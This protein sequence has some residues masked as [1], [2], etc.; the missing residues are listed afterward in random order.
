[1]KTPEQN[2]LLRGWYK[3]ATARPLQHHLA[4]SLSQEKSDLCS[5]AGIDP[6][7]ANSWKLSVTLLTAG[8]AVLSCRVNAAVHHSMS[9]GTCECLLLCEAS[10]NHPLATS[11]SPCFHSNVNFSISYCIVASLCLQDSPF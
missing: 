9:P 11:G 2:Q 8:Q 7:G 3:P 10:K 6:G 4:Q 1:M 5:N